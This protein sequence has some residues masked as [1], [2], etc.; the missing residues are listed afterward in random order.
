MKQCH[1]KEMERSK[2]ME[3]EDKDQREEQVKDKVASE[4][5]LRFHEPSSHRDVDTFSAYL[6]R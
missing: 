4:N 6:G 5:Y 1:R 2:E 3:M